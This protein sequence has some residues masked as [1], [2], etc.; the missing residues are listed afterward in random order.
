MARGVCPQWHLKRKCR[1]AYNVHFAGSV[2]VFALCLNRNTRA[3]GHTYTRTKLCRGQ[4]QRDTLNVWLATQRQWS[5]E[6]NE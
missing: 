3:R 1:Q 6:A 2:C 4:T 5:S